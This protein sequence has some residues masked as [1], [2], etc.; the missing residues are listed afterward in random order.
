MTARNDI[1]QG[2]EYIV[3]SVVLSNGIWF[4]ETWDADGQMFAAGDYTTQVV[5]YNC[6]VMSY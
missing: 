3:H 5:H 4:D 1:S 6:F 2:E